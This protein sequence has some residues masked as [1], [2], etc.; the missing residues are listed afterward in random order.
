MSSSHFLDNPATV[1]PNLAYSYYSD[2]HGFGKME[3]VLTAYGSS[4]LYTSLD[5]LCKWVI[6]FQ[7]G[8]AS[9]NPLYI[10]M[11]RQATL[12]SGDTVPYG[13]GLE[14]GKEK[15][16]RTITHTGAWAGYRTIIKNYPD[17]NISL[18]LLS[19]CND[20]SMNNNYASAVLN[21]FLKS[22]FKTEKIIAATKIPV[23][24][25]DS[26]IV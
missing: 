19:N 20:N 26:T 24:K 21:L 12:N 8:I 23:L 17:Q 1:I 13:Y 6:H 5:D 18:I 11:V 14:I 25:L 10:H 9:N 7:Q 4:S 22:K 16:L 3:N 15:G 2:E